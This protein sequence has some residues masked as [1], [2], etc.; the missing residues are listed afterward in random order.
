MWFDDNCKS[1]QLRESRERDFSVGLRAMGEV[2]SI[3]KFWQL[4]N[5]AKPPS[6]LDLGSNYHFFRFGIE[7][8]WEDVANKNG[9][10]WVITMKASPG[11]FDEFWMFVLLGIIGEVIDL[12]DDVCGVVVS[13]Y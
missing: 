1:A 5:Y 2:S 13:I 10:S 11:K 4:F 9:G 8:R 3:E 7:P 6:S 12:T